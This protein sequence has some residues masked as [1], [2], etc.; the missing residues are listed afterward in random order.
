MEKLIDV[1]RMD[2]YYEQIVKKRFS[3]QMLALL[4]SSI[5]A[6]ALIIVLSVYLS[7]IFGWLVPVSILLLGL[8]IFL[9]WYLVKNSG[10]EYEYTFVM[11]EMRIERIKGK[12]KRRKVTAFDV[13][14]V[15]DIGLYYDQETGQR[16]V[17][18]SKYTLVLRAAENDMADNT[19]YAIIHDKVRHKPALLLFTPNE[20]TLNKIKPYLSIDM[21]KKFLELEK[22]K[23][24][25]ASANA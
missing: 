6:I 8:G 18:K 23:K 22:M 24:A 7:G 13:K 25:S 17:D 4:V 10:V 20:M 5:S 16:S 21:K 12:N 9:I 15:D 3:P 19:Y 2:N 11:G 14:A 1:G